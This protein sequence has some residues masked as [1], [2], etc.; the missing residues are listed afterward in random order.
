[1]DRESTTRPTLALGLALMIAAAPG[2]QCGGPT[3]DE[4]LRQ[5]VLVGTARD[6]WFNVTIIA[7]ATALPSDPACPVVTTA[8]TT[9][10]FEG[11]CTD[12]DGV[13]W[14]GTATLDGSFDGDYTMVWTGYTQVSDGDCSGTPVLATSV[15]DGMLAVTGTATGVASFTADVRRNTTVDDPACTLGAIDDRWNYAGSVTDG[16]D[17]DMDMAPDDQTFEGAGLVS[18]IIEGDSYEA[19][20]ETTDQL[21]DRNA[22]DQ[23]PLSGTSTFAFGDAVGV[24]VNDGATDCD[25]PPTGQWTLGGADQGEIPIGGVC[26]IARLADGGSPCAL[27]VLLLSLGL[28]AL[29][30]RKA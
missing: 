3:P 7:G 21:V 27:G 24:L 23:E 20:A 6:V 4:I 11:G 1:M 15:I 25:D 19:S 14:S 28:A 9:T 18:R 16:P 30:R 5:I 12:V 8:G 10:T 22:C 2:C 17:T 13:D 26:T 29:L